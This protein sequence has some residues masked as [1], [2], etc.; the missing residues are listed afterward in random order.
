M[1]FGVGGENAACKFYLVVTTVLIMN[2][3]E[4]KEI[5]FAFGLNIFV[6]R[7]GTVST[8]YL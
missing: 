2:W 7:L 1:V 8:D 6:C 4:G 3:F 5:A